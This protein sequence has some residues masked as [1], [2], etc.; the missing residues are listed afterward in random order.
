MITNR[1]EA[2]YAL[3]LKVAA[4]SLCSDRHGCVIVRA[5]SVLSLATNRAVVSHPVSN[6]YLK[7][8]LH[9]EQRAILRAHDCEGATLYSAR[10]HVN[11]IST[12]CAMCQTLIEEAGISRIVFHD[13]RKLVKIAS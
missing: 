3:A 7:Q 10:L 5:G 9:A 13:G 2:W 12:P 4:D 8:A 11:A 1:D 6:R